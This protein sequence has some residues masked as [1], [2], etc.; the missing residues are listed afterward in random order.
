MVPREP[1]NRWDRTSAASSVISAAPLEL[2][3]AMSVTRQCDQGAMNGPN[4]ITCLSLG[5]WTGAIRSRQARIARPRFAASG[6]DR[7]SSGPAGVRQAGKASRTRASLR[8]STRLH[9][10]IFN[11]AMQE[12]AGFIPKR[13]LAMMVI[14][15]SFLP[16]S[17]RRRWQIARNLKLH[18]IPRFA[19][20]MPRKSHFLW[21]E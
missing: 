5:G 12:S 9:W 21:E 2:R 7:M 16:Q 17:R 13:P 3:P 8:A 4:N 18:P 6:L 14:I 15:A 19:L 11:R 10:S 20:L 1:M